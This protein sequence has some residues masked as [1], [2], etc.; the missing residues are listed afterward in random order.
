MVRVAVLGANGQVGAEVCLLLSRSPSLELVP[1]CR[2]RSGS[3][4][5]RSQGL[6]CRHGRPAAPGEAGRLFSDCDAIVNFALAT[7]N[8]AQIRNIEDQLVLNAF[9]YSKRDA[10]IVHFSTQTVYGDPAPGRWIRWLSP[11]GRTKLATERTVRAAARRKSAYIL[12][13]GHVCGELQSI[14]HQIRS[15]LLSGSAVLPAIDVPSNTV[16]TVAIADALH[17]IIASEVPPGTYDLMNTPQWTWQQVYAYEAERCGAE[18]A[19]VLATTGAPSARPSMARRL[20]GALSRLA[21]NRFSRE[22]VAKVLAFAPES[23]SRRL[24]AVWYSR[25]VRAE[26]ADLRRD[27]GPPP[28][29]HLSWVRNGRVPFPQPATLELLSQQP[30]EGLL[31]PRGSRWPLDLAD[32]VEGTALS[33]M[34]AQTQTD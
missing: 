9:A 6:A 11:Y 34:S 28:A 7:G 3:A 32:A 12:R 21:A 14:S 27:M 19:T 5:L 15:D 2:N 23:T 8:P 22:A 4:F 16:L 31:Q 26:I 29:E 18:K 20:A 33:V 25:R 30:Y 10:V 17:R 1:I 13:L 24:Q